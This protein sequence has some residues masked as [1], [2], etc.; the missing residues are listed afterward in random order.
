MEEHLR[1]LPEAGMHISPPEALTVGQRFAVFLTTAPRCSLRHSQEHRLV[2]R[3]REDLVFDGCTLKLAEA[4]D[5]NTRRLFGRSLKLRQVSAGGSG[6]CK[7]DL[8]VLGNIVFDLSL[9]PGR[10]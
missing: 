9:S 5:D 8:N 4:L 7:A 3:T 10:L 6:A 2:V 1:P